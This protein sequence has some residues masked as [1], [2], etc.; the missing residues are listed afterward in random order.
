MAKC[1][2]SIFIAVVLS[3]TVLANMNLYAQ[4]TRPATD[5]PS[6]RSVPDDLFVGEGGLCMP[7]TYSES[8]GYAK[9]WIKNHPS[10]A[11]GYFC[12]GRINAI[13]WAEGIVTA[14]G[15]GNFD[16]V[17]DGD[18]DNPP[19]FLWDSLMLQR[20][21]KN[22]ITPES[23]RYLSDCVA[24]YRKAAEIEP[25]NPLYQLALGR[26]LEQSGDPRGAIESYRKAYQLS[27]ES[28]LKAKYCDLGDYGTVS[29]KAG[30]RLLVLL[31]TEK[32]AGPD[33]TATIKESLRKLRAKPKIYHASSD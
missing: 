2:H 17:S 28:D 5:T 19:T 1:V 11:G 18:R 10:E 30:E 31:Q 27:I 22:A 15:E 16:L 8:I 13:A 33:D 3:L 14:D 7:A 4:T 29:L 25:V 9:A 12:L 23:Q 26:S 20:D 32:P 6:T 21:P 24:A